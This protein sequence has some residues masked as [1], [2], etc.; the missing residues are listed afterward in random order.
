MNSEVDLADLRQAC[1]VLP[2]ALVIV[3]ADRRILWLNDA[4]ERL[5]GLHRERDIGAL[6]DDC[7][8]GGKLGNWLRNGAEQTLN[9]QPS[10]ALPDV[11]L[12][13]DLIPFNGSKHLLLARDTS[14]LSRLEQTRSDFVA[15]VSH[16]LRTPLTVIHGYLEML[17]PDE[18]PALAPVLK[19]MRTQ[20]QRMGQIVEDL[21]TLTRLETQESLEDERVAWRHARQ[22]GQG[23]R[24]AQPRPSQGR[25]QQRPTPTCW[26]RPRTCTAPSPTWSATPCA[27]RPPG[28]HP[29]PLASA[30]RGRRVLGQDTGYGIPA[31][32]L[33]RLTER[34]YRVSTSRSRD[35]GGTGL[36]L[37]IVKHVLNLHQ[38]RMRIESTPGEGSTFRCIFDPSRLLEPGEDSP[39]RT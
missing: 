29:H 39:R 25:R 36:G 2:N 9:D 10:P 7:L 6:L 15:N 14:Q 11:Q 24:G 13:I 31:D 19:E 4:A 1:N 32:H 3:A 26:A 20:S 22:P 16:E 28:Q 34:F 38:A 35:L 12:Q 21:L 18:V 37:S 30:P 27:T 23:G 17:D 5:L 8:G 33:A